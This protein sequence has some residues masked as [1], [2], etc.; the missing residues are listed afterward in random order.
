MNCDD[1]YDET[2]IDDSNP[3]CPNKNIY[4]KTLEPLE[5]NDYLI[6]LRAQCEKNDDAQ[7]N[8]KTTKLRIGHLRCGN[9][10]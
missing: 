10:L 9:G 1:G 8:L 7:L 4:K 6:N 5:Y 2:M 3:C